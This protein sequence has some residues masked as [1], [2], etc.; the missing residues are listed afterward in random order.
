MDKINCLLLAV[1]ER[2]KYHCEKLNSNSEVIRE[3]AKKM[4]DIELW[5]MWVLTQ[6][7]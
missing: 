3:V 4:I 5:E 1:A 7:E 2:Y 6:G